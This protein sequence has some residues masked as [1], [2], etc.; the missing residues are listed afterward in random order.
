MR[1]DDF[2]QELMNKMTIRGFKEFHY[3]RSAFD[4]ISKKILSLLIEQ[5]LTKKNRLV[6]SYN[7]IAKACD[8]SYARVRKRITMLARYEIIS[9]EHQYQH[10][11]I[12][13]GINSTSII[14]INPLLLVIYKNKSIARNLSKFVDDHF[15]VGF[16]KSQKGE[17]VK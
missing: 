7:M 8:I 4:P 11:E 10:E 14:R 12:N 3:E 9:I 15:K 5:A 2:C 6:I 1:I 16:E 17:S 13:E